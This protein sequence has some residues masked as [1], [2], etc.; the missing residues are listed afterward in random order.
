MLSIIAD[1]VTSNM[2]ASDLGKGFVLKN[3]PHI[4]DVMQPLIMTNTYLRQLEINNPPTLL[5]FLSI[6]GLVVSVT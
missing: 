6:F 1:T 4:D 3:A 5:A 2:K